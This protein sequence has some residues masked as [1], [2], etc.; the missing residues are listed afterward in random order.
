M[1]LVC[2]TIR[3]VISHESFVLIA[4]KLC[5]VLSDVLF[6]TIIALQYALDEDFHDFVSHLIV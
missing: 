5:D 2:K 4:W 1:R 3:H 6:P